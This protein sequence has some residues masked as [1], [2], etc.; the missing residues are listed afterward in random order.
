MIPVPL[1]DTSTVVGDEMDTES[2]EKSARVE[3]EWDQLEGWRGIK[4]KAEET[5][6]GRVY[7]FKQHDE[8]FWFEH[9]SVDEKRAYASIMVKKN[10]ALTEIDTLT[11]CKGWDSCCTCLRRFL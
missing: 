2:R 7:R 4:R 3:N 11:S 5:R 1:Y 8:P 10:I 6:E 9:A